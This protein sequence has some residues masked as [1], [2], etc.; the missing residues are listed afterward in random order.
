MMN[1][2]KKRDE[3]ID[4]PPFWCLFGFRSR[5]GNRPLE[6]SWLLDIE[7]ST[8]ALASLCHPNK[9]ANANHSLQGSHFWKHGKQTVP[10]L[11]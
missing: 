11:K 4:C 6:T 7:L 2:E 5:L 3:L 10:G 8:K 1:L 9:E